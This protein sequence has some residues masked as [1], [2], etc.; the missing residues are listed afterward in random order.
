MKLRD[1]MFL[2]I[3]GLLVISGMVLNSLLSGN[4][5]AQEIQKEIKQEEILKQLDDYKN[6]QQEGIQDRWF[7]R[8]DR[9]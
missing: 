6:S 7:R 5:D 2:V 8:Q 4:A 9:R 3:G 1:M